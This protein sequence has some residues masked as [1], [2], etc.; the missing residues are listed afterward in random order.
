MGRAAHIGNRLRVGSGGEMRLRLTDPHV[1]AE[2]LEVE[3]AAGGFMV[4]DLGSTNGTWFEGSKI[5]TALVPVGATLKVGESYLRIVPQ[6]EP[7]E[8]APSASRR[9]GEL[10]AESLAMREVFAV[11]ELAARSDATLL[12][13]GETGTGKELVARAVHDASARRDKPF[14][15]VDCGALPEGVMESELFGHVKGAFTGAERPRDGAFLRANGGTVFLDEL[16]AVPLAVQARLL[17]VLEERKVR[18][19]GSDVEKPLDVRVIA[20]SG[21]NLEGRVAAGAFRPDLYYRLSVVSVTLPPLRAR[22]EDIAPIVARLLERRGFAA[23]PIAGENLARLTAHAWPGNVRELR[24]VVDRALALSPNAQQF[25]E[26][27]LKVASGDEDAL[28]VRTDLPFK[29]AKEAV[30]AAFERAYLKSMHEK[31]D[32]NVSAGA[33]EAQVDRKHWRSLL[34][35]HGLVEGDED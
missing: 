23:G 16:S 27:K 7:M 3:R 21:P 12:V 28:A 25:S 13:Q 1:S 31:H 4:K 18:Q 15:A 9:F 10:V 35:A 26:L 6:P 19:L 32:G 14:V 11:L 33:R 5:Q 30:H 22:R 34:R 20:A 24:N 17:R 29:E 2:H 8:V